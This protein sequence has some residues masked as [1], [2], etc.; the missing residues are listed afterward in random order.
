MT[1]IANLY[2]PGQPPQP[3]PAEQFAL[4]DASGR[5]Q[6][7]Q[8]VA[9][10]LGCH[11]SLL[12][13]LASGPGYVAYSIFDCEGDVNAAV[14]PLLKAVTKTEWGNENEDEVLRGNILVIRLT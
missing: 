11:V 6:V 1:T 3:I 14:I 4:P 9:D 2:R 13:V 8:A 10:A 12:D 5:A 7:T